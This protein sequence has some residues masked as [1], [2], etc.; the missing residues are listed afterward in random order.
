MLQADT[1]AL[2]QN[3]NQNVLNIRNL[4]L[5]Y[6][7][8][9]Y[10]TIGAQSA[11]IGG[12]AYNAMT[13][14]TFNNYIFGDPFNDDPS[15]QYSQ[16]IGN[17]FK[18]LSSNPKVIVFW[19]QFFQSLF[20]ICSAVCLAAA[21]YCIFITLILQVFGSG[22]AL[23]GPVGSMAKATKGL[24]KEMFLTFCVYN[25][26]LISFGLCSF[27][28]FWLVM[29]IAAA[30]ISSVVTIIVY[31]L[32]YRDSLRIYDSFK[33]DMRE[34]EI[35]LDAFEDDY[36][37]DDD[38]YDN[39]LMLSTR[40]R[41]DKR[42]VLGSVKNVFAGLFSSD[43][44]KE[45]KIKSSDYIES[46]EDLKLSTLIKV[47]E[48]FDEAFNNEEINMKTNKKVVDEITDTCTNFLKEMEQVHVVEPEVKR[49]LLAFKKTVDLK[50]A[51]KKH[52]VR[53]GQL[54]KELRVLDKNNN[55]ISETDKTVLKKTKDYSQ[56][57]FVGLWKGSDSKD[58]PASLLTYNKDDGGLKL[59]EKDVFEKIDMNKSPSVVPIQLRKYELKLQPLEER[60]Q[61]IKRIED[62]EGR[63]YFDLREL[64]PEEQKSIKENKPRPAAEGD[65]YFLRFHLPATATEHD[66]VRWEK[67][68]ATYCYLVDN[69]VKR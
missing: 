54:K 27:F 61:K 46:E 22:L 9:F 21:I 32:S 16:N 49:Q 31:A 53:Y 33:F 18:P 66:L 56:Y 12:F 41:K 42:S 59:F 17:G 24:K 2:E 58:F 50:V 62:Q 55:V 19:L 51:V 13:Q 64:T 29:D 39:G 40:K 20:Y 65:Q 11:L 4:E 48:G 23:L 36:D 30:V 47:L 5:N 35:H 8:S 44:S 14:V 26:M 69:R 52:F 15:A 10:I 68:L 7:N 37:P 45:V 6:Y 3:V 57:V 1:R 38:E 67:C 63:Y 43:E 25:V 60:L 34:P 28:S